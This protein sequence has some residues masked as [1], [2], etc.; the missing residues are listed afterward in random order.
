MTTT[1]EKLAAEAERARLAY[2]T[3]QAK[4]SAV[5]E[6]EAARRD[7]AEA[8]AYAARLPEYEGAKAVLQDAYDAFVAAV[9]DGDGATILTTWVTWHLKWSELA[10]WVFVVHKKLSDRGLPII[11]KRNGPPD[12]ARDLGR[13]M[14]IV[15]KEATALYLAERR[16]EIAAEVG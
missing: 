15:E 11:R 10:A 16:A 4:A 5:S 2:E 14:L 8:V 9:R 1:V 7:A 3:A 6:E 12:F 13:A